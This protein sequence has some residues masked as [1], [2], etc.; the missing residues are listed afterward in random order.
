MKKPRESEDLAAAAERIAA[1]RA[2]LEE[3]AAQGM[4]PPPPRGTPRR[5]PWVELVTLPDG[6]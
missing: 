1:R 5:A 2:M 4:G 3:L 6:N